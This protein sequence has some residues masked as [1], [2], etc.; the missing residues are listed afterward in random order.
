MYEIFKMNE[1]LSYYHR[2]QQRGA[3]RS[4]LTTSINVEN[5]II[6]GGLAGISTMLSL[7]ERGHSVA[8][9]ESKTVGFG[10][11]GRNGGFLSSGF[12]L[13]VSE[14]EKKVGLSVTKE[15]FQLSQKGV[16]LVLAR[17]NKFCLEDKDLS[18]GM[19]RS[20][21]FSISDTLER[22]VEYMNNTFNTSL[23]YWPEKIVK[24]NYLTDRYRDAIFDPYGYQIN[25]LNYLNKCAE[26]AEELGASIYETTT[27]NKI[28]KSADG[29]KVYT[30][31]GSVIAKNVILCTSAYRPWLNFKV[32]QGILPIETF[33]LVTEPLGDRLSDAIKLP[34]P[35]ADTRRIENYYR[36]L[37]DT[38]LLWGGGISTKQNPNKLKKKML[39]DLLSV[40][41]QLKGIKGDIAWSGTMGYGKHRMPQ[42]GRI[43]QNLWYNQ[44]FGGHGLNTTSMGGELIAA[45][46]AEEDD[47]YKIF[48]PFNLA[49]TGRP[50]GLIAV[51]AIYWSWK[52][53]DKFI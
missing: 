18:A 40:Y 36:P 20:S 24:E 26:A 48:H 23:A 49:F 43:D 41:P 6:G 29:Y 46:I 33:V 25:P 14:I 12:S 21:W 7:V 5:C 28:K 38:R 22:D 45:A 9:L 16:E 3:I 8:L 34:Y 39:S 32:A 47:T 31:E 1:F 50:L 19:V 4:N 44:G 51:Q 17:S 42:I 53:R 13:G 37:S 27:V 2:I 10:A 11:S 15:L 30:R 52:L 35:V